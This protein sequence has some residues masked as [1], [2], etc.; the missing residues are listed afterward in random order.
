MDRT[1]SPEATTAE[2]TIDTT[3]VAPA[4]PPAVAA[5][6]APP[7]TTDATPTAAPVPG[8]ESAPADAKKAVVREFKETRHVKVPL[9]DAEELALLREARAIDHEIDQA[10][11][12]FDLKKQAHNEKVK[13][14][15]KKR[16]EINAKSEETGSKDVDVIRYV[17][18]T[19]GTVWV[20]RQ[21]TKEEIE[22]RPISKDEAQ[23]TLELDGPT[24]HDEAKEGGKGK[25]LGPKL[26]ELYTV[27]V[28]RK[29]G[30]SD[31]CRDESGAARIFSSKKNADKF[32]SE[33]SQNDDGD[34][35]AVQVADEGAAKTPAPDAPEPEVS[36][37]APP[38]VFIVRRTDLQTGSAGIC[39]G[40]DGVT[41]R[42][43]ADVVDAAEWAEGQ[44]R[45]FGA[46]TKFT[47]EEQAPD[48]DDASDVPVDAETLAKV[49]AD[50]APA[51]APKRR[52]RPKGSKN[53]GADA[54]VAGA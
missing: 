54:S 24:P 19:A 20:V 25:K 30:T 22:R 14:L 9:P 44:N 32:A 3:D 12:D 11:F 40:P 48:A 46:T 8:L 26:V 52:G 7:P 27:R 35:F 42:T 4:T 31:L 43:F 47:V 39:V 51:E 10:K 38:S 23:R 29:D 45:E 2:S 5:D 6:V 21:D 41:P 50:D 15:E 13:Q 17:D 36:R 28:T 33:K 49:E 18:Y 1:D 34:V 16:S 37:P 53:K